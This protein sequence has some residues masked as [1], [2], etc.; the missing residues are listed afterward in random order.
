MRNRLLLTTLLLATALLLFWIANRGAYRN[1][2]Q[3]DSLDNIGLAHAIGWDSILKP[4]AVPTVPVDNFR[5]VGMAFL[6]LMSNTAG[7]RFPPYIAALQ[8][9]HV[10][11]ALLAFLLLRRLGLSTLAAAA[12]VLFFVFH[13]A[14]FTVL[15][16]PMYV[17]DLLCGSFCLLS[18]LTY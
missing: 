2:F 11:N 9:L 14:L 17:F 8:I 7:L 18:L 13:M 16:E 3:A 1:Y 12:G 6:K 4:L 10:I 5:P 15:W